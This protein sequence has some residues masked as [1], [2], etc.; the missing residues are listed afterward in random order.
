LPYAA[1]CGN[2]IVESGEECDDRNVQNGDGCSSSCLRE[3]RSD[4]FDLSG[5]CGDGR[6]Q[7]LALEQSDGQ[8]VVGTVI[9]STV[10][11]AEANNRT[12]YPFGWVGEECDPGENG[13]WSGCDRNTC[14]NLGSTAVDAVCGNG[15]IAWSSNR[16]GEDCDDS[17]RLGGDGCS[18]QCLNE[19]SISINRVPAVCGDGVITAPF[20]TCDPKFKD[21]SWCPSNCLKPGV[22]IS[23][24]NACGDGV[25]QAWEDCDVN[26]PESGDGCSEFC[27]FLG[28]SLNHKSPSI[29]G[30][31]I[32]G[33]GE[34]GLCEGDGQGA[35]V[36][37]MQIARIL[38]SAPALVSGPQ[39][40]VSATIL[41]NASEASTVRGRATYTLSCSARTDRDCKDPNV[42]GVGAGNCC[43]TRPKIV[44]V[45]PADNSTDV[46]LN[47][48]TNFEVT[49]NLNRDLVAEN[50]ELEFIGQGCPSG[51]TRKTAE[52]RI[53]QSFAWMRIYWNKLVPR[54]AAQNPGICIMPV[55][56]VEL[57][58]IS[59]N[60]ND[61]RHLVRLFTESAFAENSPYRFRILGDDNIENNEFVGLA[62][63]IGARLLGTRET[64]FRT[65]SQICEVDRVDVRDPAGN[66]EG[67]FGQSGQERDFIASAIS[68]RGGRSQEIQS[69]EGFYS[70]NWLNWRESSNGVIVDVRESNKETGKIAAAR[71]SGEALAIA[72]LQIANSDKKVAGALNVV[73]FFCE[74]PWPSME[75]YPFRDSEGTDSSTGAVEGR[76]WTNFATYY[77]K[78]RGVTGIN[79]DLPG[80]RVTLPP[81]QPNTGGIFKE[82]LFEVM[83][84]SGDAIG[85]RVAGNPQYLTPIEWY[86]QQGFSGNPT[87]ITLDGLPAI[88]DGRTVY[89][90]APNQDK[91]NKIFSNVYI[92]SHNQLASQST[93]DIFSQFLENFKVLANI[94]NEQICKS[95]SRTGDICSNNLDCGEAGLCGNL[96]DQLIRDARRINDLVELSRRIDLYA[97]ANGRCSLTNSQ[98]CTGN[99]MCP[100]GETCV[101]Q[102]PRL[103]SGTFVPGMSVSTWP[104]W[105]ENLGGLVGA[106][107]IDPVNKHHAGCPLGEDGNENMTCF[108]QSSGLYQCKEGSLVYH[109]RIEPAGKYVLST[110]LEYRQGFWASN[111]PKPR[112]GRLHITV[113]LQY[114]AS[115]LFVGQGD[116]PDVEALR[117][118]TMAENIER[119]GFASA[120]FICKE[121]NSFGNSAVCGDGIVGQGEVCEPG[122]TRA[123]EPCT[124]ADS[125]PGLR[126]V[127]CA[128]DCRSFIGGGECL[129]FSCGNGVVEIGEQCDDGVNN[130]QYGFCGIDC[131]YRAGSAAFCGDGLLSAGEVCDCGLNG[132]G[133][134]S[135]GGSCSA[136]AANGAYTANPVNGCSWD[137]RGP[138][139][140]CGDRVVQ[141]AAGEQCDGNVQ[142]WAGFLCS[143][144]TPCNIGESC[145]TGEICGQASTPAAGQ[146]CTPARVCVAGNISTLGQVCGSNAACDTTGSDGRTLG[147]GLCSMDPIPR[148]RVRGCGAPGTANACSFGN[149]SACVPASTCGNGVVEEGEQCDDG[150]RENGDSCTNACRF[151]VCGDG[152]VRSGIEQCD[153]GALNG[154]PCNA[155]Y[156]GNCSFCST[157]CNLVVNTGEFCGDSVWNREFEFCDGNQVRFVYVTTSGAIDGYCL[158]EE[159]GTT[160]PGG[161]AVCLEA[162]V[163]NG[164]ARNGQLI[165][166]NRGN[167]LPT[168]YGIYA[169]CGTG[170]AQFPDCNRTCTAACPFTYDFAT[171]QLRSDVAGA[172]LSNEITLTRASDQFDSLNTAI[173]QNASMVFPA[174]RVSSGLIGDVEIVVNRPSKAIVNFVLDFSSS[175]N[176]PIVRNGPSRMTVMITSLKAG[177]DQLFDELDE[178]VEIRIIGYGPR[179][180]TAPNAVINQISSLSVLMEQDNNINNPVYNDYIWRYHDHWGIDNATN[181]S[182]KDWEVAWY[183]NTRFNV[184]NRQSLLSFI[185]SLEVAFNGEWWGPTP[186]KFGLATA[187]YILEQDW[188]SKPLEVREN[189]EKVLVY[190]TDGS[191]DFA[192]GICAI[193]SGGCFLDGQCPGFNSGD[194]RNSCNH[195]HPNAQYLSMNPYY[196]AC[197]AFDKGQQV[198]TLSLLSGEQIKQSELTRNNVS[199]NTIDGLVSQ[200]HTGRSN[201]SICQTL[202]DSQ[203]WYVQNGG[204]RPSTSYSLV[205]DRDRTCFQFGLSKAAL[206]TSATNHAACM[207]SGNPDPVSQI[208]YAYS[209]NTEAEFSRAFEQIINSINTVQLRYGGNAGIDDYVPIREGRGVNIPLPE[210]FECMPGILS[211]PIS[212]AYKGDEGG[213]VRISNLR[214]AHCAQ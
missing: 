102:S 202:F 7:R 181:V 4:T 94:E 67:F 6:L 23:Q 106:M 195:S 13:D 87:A 188:N 206:G 72:E 40:Q 124:L 77:C 192:Q 10:S 69:I 43:S 58:K 186:S 68:I 127:S 160:K 22:I 165:L 46:C 199:N 179:I 1:V 161:G 156:G 75:A 104:S 142:S 80:L 210:G 48:L 177:V 38:D 57:I 201:S 187:S 125:R 121:G 51:H 135:G 70:W 78:D 98:A 120:S 166:R 213:R 47:A 162:G 203:A 28:S 85:L 64:T 193:T 99:S 198:Y 52:G 126:T 83:D 107:P 56:R 204:R 207:A 19:G 211:L 24:P 30:D 100:A 144:N 50:I 25:V 147:D 95:G 17:N 173:R 41:A 103:A 131:T 164:G 112:T 12:T 116:S 96:K 14:M 174:C 16:G 190:M 32:V 63:N 88:R 132:S 180:T 37:P 134:A 115:L 5:T 76:A 185:D 157:Q 129:P 61:N 145:G 146:A 148:H 212:V 60:I 15:D 20:E 168:G 113:P 182:H 130:G 89:V 18:A 111:L 35:R 171:V 27:K 155:P 9:L 73:T 97:E 137:C 92:V 53:S 175:M 123:T 189:T 90:V 91:E 82:Y 118:K 143:D 74:N 39:N 169:S 11:Q 194:R 54:V 141:S 128:N 136:S 42:N 154:I 149:W 105:N 197:R 122:V 178:E 33:S 49:T 29:C 163:C 8:I 119:S 3:A 208:D 167:V 36:A 183:S 31:G 2:G 101:P 150:N 152:F 34:Y 133:I 191:F 79:D 44:N 151:N 84:G 26:N 66:P 205:S 196:S 170:V 114:L 55:S 158:P 59:Q 45:I 139:A 140:Y 209:G 62:S 138:A 214:F 71:E 110:D 81:Q 184:N 109:Y 65:G 172:G 200:L 153:S 108:D 117:N 176:S 93:Q 86:R 159:I 21:Q